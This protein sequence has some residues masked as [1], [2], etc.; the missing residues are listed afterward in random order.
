M[1]IV[2]AVMTMMVELLLVQEMLAEAHLWATS[3]ARAR[4]A[5]RCRQRAGVVLSRSSFPQF[6]LIL[7]LQMASAQ[8][9]CGKTACQF[10]KQIGRRTITERDLKGLICAQLAGVPVREENGGSWSCPG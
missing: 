7:G 5:S 9:G 8:S 1:M 10:G 2:V 4:A 3:T 6:H